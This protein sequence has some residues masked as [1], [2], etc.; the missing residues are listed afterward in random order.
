MKICRICGKEFEP[1]NKGWVRQYC[2]DCVPEGLN[3][4]DRTVYKRRA[5]KRQGVKL[6]GGKCICCGETRPHILNFHHIDSSQKDETPAALIKNSQTEAF[7]KEIKKCVLLCSNCHQDFH[8]QE[9]LNGITLKKYLEQNSIFSKEELEKDLEIEKREQNDIVAVQ[10]KT[11]IKHYCS[12]CGKELYSKTKS[13]LCTDCCHASRR[14]VER[15]DAVT[16]AQEIVET[17]F[18]AVGRKYGVSDNAIRKWCKSYGLPTTKN[19]LKDWLS[20]Q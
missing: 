7:F 20:Q 19:E 8:Y 9:S 17:N 3:T 12:K 2:F 16:L 1:I 10:E 5:I 15:P 6:L 14:T 13:G 18:C 4:S 11:Y